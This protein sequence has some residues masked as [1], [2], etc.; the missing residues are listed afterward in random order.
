MFSAFNQSL[1]WLDLS[2]NKLYGTLPSSFYNLSALQYLNLSRNS[3]SGTISSAI[4]N[5]QQLQNVSMFCNKFEGTL[6]ERIGDLYRLQTLRL[7]NNSFTG[8]IPDTIGKLS[9]LSFLSLR[10][11]MINGTIPFSLGNLRE[12]DQLY[13]YDMQLEGEIPSSIGNLQKISTLAMSNNKLTGRLPS[14]LTNLRNLKALFLSS[15]RLNGTLETIWT[16]TAMN[17][18]Y[19]YSNMFTGT[20]SNSIGNVRNLSSLYMGHNQLH[21]TLPTAISKLSK[22]TATDLSSNGF[23]G[24]ISESLFA[25]AKLLKTFIVSDNYFSGPPPIIPS[26]NLL[27]YDISHNTFT[28]YIPSSFFGNESLLSIFSAS[29]NCLERDIPDSVCDCKELTQLVLCGININCVNQRDSWLSESTDE[30]VV[31]SC[32]WSM[33]SLRRLYLAA[34]SYYGVIES[35]NLS[36]IEI[37]SIGFNRFRGVVPLNDGIVY[38]MINF[39]ISHNLFYGTL[40]DVTVE[41]FNSSSM[42]SYI[43]DIN[44]LSGHLQATRIEK[45]STVETLEGNVIYCADEPTNDLNFNKYTCEAQSYVYAMYVWVTVFGMSLFLVGFFF[46]HKRGVSMGEMMQRLRTFQQQS[47]RILQ[48]DID[49][50]HDKFPALLQMIRTLD[51]MICLCMKSSF[52]ILLAIIIVYSS[53][54][55]CR[56]NALYRTHESRMKDT[57]HSHNDRTSLHPSLDSCSGTS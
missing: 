32:L 1:Q 51:K 16:L 22:L 28:G 7:Y 6:T 13:L 11:N 5:M 54:K 21:G 12:L 42:T 23:V 43:A 45:F 4:G 17:D 3:F 57:N 9:A 27:I 36:N 19:L 35:S 40:E 56:D 55:Y 20:I 8:T 41:P 25:N 38:K 47:V 18:V 15:N 14:T 26:T 2:A 29:S 24:T 30:V 53:L 31:P 49:H 33:H 10:N 48:D 52:V 50:V 37:L 39:D 44:R 46:N 34:N